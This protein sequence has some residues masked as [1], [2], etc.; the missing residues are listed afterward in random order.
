MPRL[1]V[2]LILVLMASALVLPAGEPASTDAPLLVT[3]AGEQRELA[4]FSHS[5]ALVVACGAY[6][7]LPAISEAGQDAQ[8]VRAVLQA[9]RFAVT[10]LSDPTAGALDQGLVDFLA[11]WGGDPDAR[12]VLYFCC[13]SAVRNGH[14][15]LLTVDSPQD[16]G[17]DQFPV[18]A[19]A[20]EEVLARTRR[21]RARHILCVF[22]S[23]IKVS[24]FAN[25]DAMPPLGLK[26]AGAAVRLVIASGSEQQ[27]L[28][29]TSVFRRAFVDGL[30]GGADAD[31]DGYILG[32]ELFNFIRERMIDVQ[33]ANP[34]SQPQTP[35]WRAFAQED[36]VIGE[37]VFAAPVME[38]AAAVVVAPQ[39]KWA[40][41]S[42]RDACGQWAEVQA[43]GVTQRMRWI[44]P[45]TFTMGSPLGEAHRLEVETPHQVT[46]SK[47][48]WLADSACTQA[49]WQGVM[50][51]NPAHFT[52]D[53]QRPVE[54]VSWDD[55]QAFL[56]A[57]NRLV[58][59]GGFG[60]PTE[61][62]REFSCRAGAGG[63]FAGPALDALAW[64]KGNSGQQTHAVKQKA[65][66]AWGLYDM[67]GNVWEWCAD[68]YGPYPLDAVTDPTGPPSG[69]VRVFRGGS[70]HY[71]G[72][73]CRSANR[74]WDKPDFRSFVLGFRLCCQSA[75]Q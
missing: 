49:L 56:T 67:H 34:G 15:F 42:G 74:S 52:G 58:S 36:E 30:A 38:S 75:R 5:A 23:S 11:R 62:Q 8:A 17:D 60:L 66:N 10:V 54:Q 2:P 55:V 32:S 29:A 22:D 72:W 31:R 4:R 50:G 33:A 6:R 39:P 45:G 44:S 40:Q 16:V 43:G 9:H 61:A 63:P 65:A 59:G 71:D 25:L 48:F 37:F 53:P 51:A 24:F 3:A 73:G 70:W 41:A 1:P 14:G 19:T 26:A 35:Q 47:G 57:M 28:P 68:F 18:H 7:S 21:A 13:R 20:L 27:A 46:L 12:L 64:Y 69:A